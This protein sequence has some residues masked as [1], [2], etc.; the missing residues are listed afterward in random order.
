[1]GVMGCNASAHLVCCTYL[2]TL[3]KYSKGVQSLDFE[4]ESKVTRVESNSLLDVRIEVKV[5]KS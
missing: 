4:S 3:S 5:S 2:L 1:M